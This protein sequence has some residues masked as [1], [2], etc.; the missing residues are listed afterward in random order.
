MGKE[1]P[2]ACAEKK[3]QS[4]LLAITGSGE[5][6]TTSCTRDQGAQ[7]PAPIKAS[8]GRAIKD[9]KTKGKGGIKTKG[10]N[11]SPSKSTRCR[12]DNKDR[13]PN[14]GDE[15]EHSPV[16]RS[17]QDLGIKH[18]GTYCDEYGEVPH[19]WIQTDIVARG[20]MF[21]CKLCHKHLWLPLDYLSGHRLGTLMKQYG[22]DEGYCRYLNKHR[23]AKI[24]MAKMQDLRIL[25]V[26][27][28]NIREFARLSDK[29]MSDND[30]DRKEV[31]ND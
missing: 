22:K 9:I 6:I 30:Y 14:R 31:K 21:Q 27:S 4:M 5:H 1:F 23:E 10:T 11:A 7:E 2:L 17:A 25:E 12:R 18:P 15:G 29:I 19:Y 13:E 3:G 26:T 20:T 28:T 24:L 8:S 16:R